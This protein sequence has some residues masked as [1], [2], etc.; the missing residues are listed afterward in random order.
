MT[1]LTMTTLA[2]V[3]DTWARVSSR[4]QHHRLVVEIHQKVVGWVISHA[5]YAVLQVGNEFPP[6]DHRFQ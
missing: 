5:R 2:G 6:P 4:F 3:W 1:W